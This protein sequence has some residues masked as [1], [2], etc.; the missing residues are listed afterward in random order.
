MLS[1]RGTADGPITERKLEHTMAPTSFRELL[2]G[3]AQNLQNCTP[4]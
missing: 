1:Q 4:R 3:I 2:A